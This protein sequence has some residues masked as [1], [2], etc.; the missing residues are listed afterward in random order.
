MIV[1]T[2]TWQVQC[3]LRMLYARFVVGENLSRGVLPTQPGNNR[4]VPVNDDAE[5]GSLGRE[6]KSRAGSIALLGLGVAAIFAAFELDAPVESYA[7][8]ATELTRSVA[9]QLSHWMD[10]PEVVGIPLAVGLCLIWAKCRDLA[11]CALAVA[12]AAAIGG[13][14][15]TVV[16]T[17]TGRARPSSTVT[18]GWYGLRHDGK[19]IVGQH[20]YASFPSG[21]TSTVAGAVGGLF[22]VRR[23]WAFAALGMIVLVAWARVFAL[24]HHFSDVTAATVLGLGVGYWI[25][26]RFLAKCAAPSPQGAK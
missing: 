23:R 5:V 12:L 11:H 7:C 19:W 10:W 18:Q 20:A 6:R 26:T 16:R 21:H 15:G 25:A 3:P 22:A 13:L 9:S 17:A 1:P 4:T 2:A 8:S 24:A 14:S